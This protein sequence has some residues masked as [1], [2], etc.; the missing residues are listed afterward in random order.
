MKELAPSIQNFVYGALTEDRPSNLFL[1]S[2]LHM[3]GYACPKDTQKSLDY[4]RRSANMGNIIARAYLFRI[5]RTFSPQDA[6]PSTIP[7]RE[8]LYDYAILGS[9]IAMLELRC[10]ASNDEFQRCHRYSTDVKG[11]VGA[12]WLNQDQMLNGI[13]QS[14]WIKDDFSL[15]QISNVASPATLIVNKRGDTILHFTA[16]CGRLKPFKTLVE[17]YKVDINIRNPLGETPTL[18]ACRS[19]HG[20]IVILCL[21]NYGADASLAA[22]NGETPLHWLCQSE[23]A[24]IE[25]LTADLIK[26]GGNVEAAT[27]EKVMHS[28]Y[29][30]TLDMDF[31]LPGTPL[32]WAVHRNRPHIVSVLLKHDAN[33]ENAAPGAVQSPLL[34]AAYWHNHDCLKVMIEHQESKV[35]TITTEGKPDLRH[36]VMYGPLVDK[37]IKG[38]DKFAMILRHGVDWLTNLHKTLDLLREKTKMINFSTRF[39]GSTLYYAVKGAHDEVVEYMFQ[40]EWLIDTINKPVGDAKRTPFLEA[41]RWNRRHICELLRDKGADVRALAANPFQ[42][43]KQN[44]FALHILAHEGHDK[45][46]SL[47][48]WLVENGLPV[49]GRKGSHEASIDTNISSLTL[50]NLKAGIYSCETAFTVAVR[51]NA[52]NLANELLRLGA[53]P[54]TLSFSSGMF[55][56]SYPLTTLGHLI[57]SNARYSTLRLEYLLDLPTPVDFVVEPERKVTALHRAAMANA[58]VSRAFDIGESVKREEFDFETNT[59]ILQTLLMKW[60][61]PKEL[62]VKCWIKGDTALHLAARNGNVGAVEALLRAGAD[63]GVLN[64]DMVSPKALAREL[65]VG[66]RDFEQVSKAFG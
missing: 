19:G 32:H 65:A 50:D 16:M 57:I 61:D 7:G 14:Q 58:D 27:R 11:G 41:V 12:S 28:Y 47:A 20:G 34:W 24:S 37:A 29:P 10:V 17:T 48:G 18:A 64:D 49:D 23:D 6:D 36:A 26:R 25:P 51:R 13:T 9:R 8:Y 59:D 33:P 39:H 1:F 60:K 22:V 62:N 4:L 38:A 55:T 53:N 63:G 2:A 46:V 56:S 15:K 43:E 40:H 30:G 42:P 5:Y 44:W 3:V 54:N 35:T 52:F 66:N 31:S 21:K 45:D